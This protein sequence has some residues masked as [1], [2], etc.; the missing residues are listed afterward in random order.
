MLNED[1][2]KATVGD[3]MK[4]AFFVHSAFGHELYL[5]LLYRKNRPESFQLFEKNRNPLK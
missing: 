1:P 5:R 3:E 4:R 2:L